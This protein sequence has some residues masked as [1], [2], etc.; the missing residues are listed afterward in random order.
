M[1][2]IALITLLLI[3]TWSFAIPI[4]WTLDGS[5]VTPLG[6]A[7]TAGGSFV[8]DADT[9]MFSDID[10]FTVGSP[11][12][13]LTFTTLAGE[14]PGDGLIF[15]Q[16]GATGEE[17]TTAFQLNGIFRSML[18]N[19]GGVLTVNPSP[20]FNFFA[21]F[22]CGGSDSIRCA[23]GFGAAVTNWDRSRVPPNTLTGMAITSVDEPGTLGLMGVAAFLALL[24][25]RRRAGNQ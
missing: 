9:G 24:M 7:G 14:A 5:L 25:Q 1:K 6:D 23:G 15:F 16:P 18:T 22:L 11:S 21:E 2:R 8:Y 12:G 13:G 3:P 20:T 4:Q 19:A 10:L 17:L